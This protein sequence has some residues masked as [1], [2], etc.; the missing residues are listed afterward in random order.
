VQALF[1]KYNPAK[2]SNEA[3]EPT[4]VVERGWTAA[5]FL[6]GTVAELNG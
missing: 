5:A 3:D 4:V 6:Y 1:L 2:P